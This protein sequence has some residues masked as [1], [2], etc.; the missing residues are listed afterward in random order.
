[1]LD[2]LLLL[3]VHHRRLLLLLRVHRLLLLLLLT[4]HRLLLLTGIGNRLLLL[5]VP[6][7]RWVILMLPLWVIRCSSLDGHSMLDVDSD[8][9]LHHLHTWLWLLC[10]HAETH[11]FCLLHDSTPITPVMNA[12]I[13]TGISL[14]P[15]FVTDMSTHRARGN[16]LEKWRERNKALG[17]NSNSN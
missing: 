16:P 6:S 13:F 3:I 11:L 17:H 8:L 1:L 14:D 10:Q 9:R 2:R 5:G 15:P 7:L 12:A 4:V